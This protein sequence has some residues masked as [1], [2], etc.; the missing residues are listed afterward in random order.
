MATKVKDPVKTEQEMYDLLMSAH[1]AG[2]AAGLVFQPRP[3]TVTDGKQNWYVSE[4]ACGFAWI[5]IQ[6]GTSRLARAAKKY[7]R[8]H[9]HYYG[10]VS[11][12]VSDFTQSID[13]KEA[14]ARAFANV[15][16]EAGF[17]NVFPQSRLD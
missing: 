11:I 10:G 8:A 17:K 16:T 1:A 13:R 7:F 5:V 12:W 15:L 14:Y 4:G 9:K 6:P 2:T 3:M